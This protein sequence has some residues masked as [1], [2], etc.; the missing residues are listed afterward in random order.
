MFHSELTTDHKTATFTG[1]VVDSPYRAYYPT[2][3]Y[4]KA[5]G[6]Y[7]LPATQKYAGNNLSNVNPMYA[8]STI[9][10]LQFY[11]ICAMMKLVVR[12]VG[13]VE[14]ITVSADQPLSGKFTV[15]TEDGKYYAEIEPTSK[16]NAAT[17]T[18]KCGSL[19]TIN[20]TVP[21][22]FYIALPQGDYT[23]LKF[24]FDSG[25]KEWVSNPVSRILEAGKIYDRD[26]LNVSLEP[27]VG[28]LPG[29]FSV[30]GDKKVLFSKGNLQ[31]V[32]AG[33]KWQFASTQYELVEKQGQDVGNNYANA[34][35]QGLFGW[36]DAQPLKTST[37]AGSYNWPSSGD[38]WGSKIDDDGTWFTLGK[39]EWTY[40]ICE[41]NGA[42]T[43]SYLGKTCQ[44]VTTADTINGLL[45]YPDD[46]D[47]IKP[48]KK[49]KISEIP[50]GCVFLPMCGRRYGTTM[51][52]VNSNGYYYT[53]DLGGGT[54]Y[55]CNP[56]FTLG[57][58]TPAGNGRGRYNGMGVRLARNVN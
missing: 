43:S 45:I 1:E 38:P 31:Y 24:T 53:C 41:R 28:A 33:A 37:Q 57:G 6:K 25:Y 36:G 55:Y 22:V 27:P 54:A 20:D 30:S 17:V 8:E 44:F 7:V 2:N 47:G 26:L 15:K 58:V 4:D 52:D 49:E 11:N 12:G 16:D 3:L 23:N 50:A 14:S 32:K 56:N 18:L 19:V 40:L 29:V 46:Y 39:D 35:V 34:D 13:F 48:A 9:T 5:E 51:N 21:T 10:D 42:S